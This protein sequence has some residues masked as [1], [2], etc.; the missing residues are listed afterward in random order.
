MAKDPKE[1][2]RLCPS[3][4]GSTTFRGWPSEVYL[5]KQILAAG[6]E[7]EGEKESFSLPTCVNNVHKVKQR[8][9]WTGRCFH[10]GFFLP[11]VMG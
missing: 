7:V 10:P 1:S 4:R 2:Q 9:P 8:S 6:S 11:S 5:A 3:T